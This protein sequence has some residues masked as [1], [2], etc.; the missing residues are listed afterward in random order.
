M[1]KKKTDFA[2]IPQSKSRCVQSV[3]FQIEPPISWANFSDNIYPIQH[4]TTFQTS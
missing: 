1:L 4:D 2:W 3:L